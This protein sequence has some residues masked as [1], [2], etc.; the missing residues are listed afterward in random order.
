MYGGSTIIKSRLLPFL[1]SNFFTTGGALTADS[2]LSVLAEAASKNREL[3]ELQDMYEHS[4]KELEADL[5][6][7]NTEL[8]DVK[9]E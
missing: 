4:L 9:D 3:D 6:D 5:D 7:R 8:Q 2:S 1:G